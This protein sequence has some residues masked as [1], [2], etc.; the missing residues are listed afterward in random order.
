MAKLNPAGINELNEG[1][2]LIGASDD[3]ETDKESCKTPEKSGKLPFSIFGARKKKER[4]FGENET[5]DSISKGDLKNSRI[6]LIKIFYQL[7]TAPIF[8]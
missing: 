1:E 8:S 2:N 4:K 5:I 3:R 7:V 6:F